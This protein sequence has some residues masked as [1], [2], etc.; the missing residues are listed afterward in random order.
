MTL[1]S[2]LRR[3]KRGY[4]CCISMSQASTRQESRMKKLICH[5]SFQ[6]W[7]SSDRNFI[8][9]KNQRKSRRLLQL[10]HCKPLIPAIQAAILVHSITSDIVALQK[11]WTS[12]EAYR[13][14]CIANEFWLQNENATCVCVYASEFFRAKILEN[15]TIAFF[16]CSVS[17]G[18]QILFHISK[19]EIPSVECR[20]THASQS[21]CVSFKN[22]QRNCLQRDIY[23]R[24]TH[25]PFI[26]PSHKFLNRNAFAVEI[27]WVAS[28]KHTF[29]HASHAQW[30]SFYRIM[31]IPAA[32]SLL[33][34]CTIQ[35]APLRAH[36]HANK[37][38]KY[39]LCVIEANYM[40]NTSQP[41][42]S[43]RNGGDK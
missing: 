28:T 39:G 2:G 22:G 25:S 14:K 32:P 23:V 13:N 41:N 5:L 17:H 7:T 38:M 8:L 29:T 36:A 20:A 30:V 31:C 6:F 4:T 3:N 42:W 11:L 12:A 37:S 18:N 27:R 24:C 43:E 19:S 9:F 21:H 10:I 1:S 40:Q 35:W 16:A 26:S 34:Q 15:S 33:Q